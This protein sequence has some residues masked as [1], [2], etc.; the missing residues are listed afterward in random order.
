VIELSFI[1]K[2]TLSEQAYERIK[3][4]ILNGDFKP[5]EQ[6]VQDELAKTLG[7]SRTPVMHALRKLE[8]DG[9]VV[10]NSKGRIFVREFTLEEM[11]HIYEIREFVEK[12]V[13]RYV[14]PI[15]TDAQIEMFRSMFESALKSENPQEEYR[16]VDNTFH[17]FLA[18]ICPN[19]ELRDIAIRS[20]VLARCLIKG[21]IRPPQETFPEHMEIL[22]CFK[23]RD[24]K[25]AEEKMRIHIVKTLEYLKK[26]LKEK[27]KGGNKNEP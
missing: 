1:R 9:L 26:L 16:K 23:K 4:M 15:I 17:T 18:E 21:L 3:E 12:L 24:P 19:K 6:L 13:C 27:E 22:D 8:S 10:R 11:V 7:I 14:T 2:V 5:G 20:G 25:C